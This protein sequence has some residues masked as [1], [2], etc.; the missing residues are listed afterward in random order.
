MDLDILVHKEDVLRAKEMLLK[1]GGTDRMNVG[2]Q[3]GRANIK[4]IP[5]EMHHRISCAFYLAGLQRAE[6]EDPTVHVGMKAEPF[7]LIPKTINLIK[8]LAT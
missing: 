8:V 6:R 4:V 2:Y 7:A 1:G 5:K 3:V